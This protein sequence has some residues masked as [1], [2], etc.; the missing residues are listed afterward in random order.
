[1]QG[2]ASRSENR[3]AYRHLI[4]ELERLGYTAPVSVNGEECR[5]IEAATHIL[6]APLTRGS[7]RAYVSRGGSSDAYILHTAYQ[8]IQVRDI[9][10]LVVETVVAIPRG[11]IILRP[12]LLRTRHAE[13]DITVYLVAY[14]LVI[15]DYLDTDTA[16]GKILLLL[17]TAYS[18]GGMDEES[19]YLY[20]RKVKDPPKPY[21]DKPINLDEAELLTFHVRKILFP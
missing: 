1:M 7:V 20:P 16:D 8:P 15:K 19:F 2:D 14:P 21:I 10:V 17:K 12:V 9:P 5:H 18:L 6:V 13:S 4:A 11:T 3:N